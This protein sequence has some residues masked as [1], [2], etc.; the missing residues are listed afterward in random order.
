MAARTSDCPIE[1]TKLA[2]KYV[3]EDRGNYFSHF[4]DSVWG[5]SL[6]DAN[7]CIVEVKLVEHPN[8]DRRHLDMPKPDYWGWI[9]PDGK[10]SMVQ[11]SWG[12][13]SMQF[14]YGEEAEEERG[15]GRAVRFSVREIRVVKDV[16]C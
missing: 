15:R 4:E 16:K 11:P 10:L 5:V 3:D 8:Q 13:F 2:N 9:E 1:F 12:Q 7:A 14:P 6:W